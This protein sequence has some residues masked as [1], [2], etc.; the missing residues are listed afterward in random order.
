MARRF[1]RIF[2]TRLEET[3][4]RRPSCDNLIE[5]NLR[6]DLVGVE[7]DLGAAVRA[8]AFN[9]IR[10]LGSPKKMRNNAIANLKA[11]GGVLE[12]SRQRLNGGQR[13][14]A[15][16]CWI[17]LAGHDQSQRRDNCSFF[18]HIC[19]CFHGEPPT[20]QTDAL[21]LSSEISPIWGMVEPISHFK[22]R[23]IFPSS[24]N[25]ANLCRIEGGFG[26]LSCFELGS[27]LVGR[28][29]IF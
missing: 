24:Q 12:G 28:W 3:P 8:R 15:P 18:Q 13:K 22:R 14:E 26:G 20:S 7:T 4:R 5:G 1:G 27:A 9:N 11:P 2:A 10:S 6:V 25:C 19:G 23:G 29:A 21:P 16:P 17:E